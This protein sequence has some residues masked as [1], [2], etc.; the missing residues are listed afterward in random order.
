LLNFFITFLYDILHY[1]V[2]WLVWHSGNIIRYISKV[3]LRWTQLI[4]AWVTIFG[5]V[6]HLCM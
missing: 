4:L 6:Y 5:R 3:T 2:R 1:T